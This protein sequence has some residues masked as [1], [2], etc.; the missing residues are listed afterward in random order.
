MKARSANDLSVS[1]ALNVVV[2]PRGLGGLDG[3]LWPERLRHPVSALVLKG[4]K[5]DWAGRPR[6]RLQPLEV[7]LPIGKSVLVERVLIEHSGE[8]LAALLLPDRGL[9]HRTRLERLS[10]TIGIDARHLLHTDEHRLALDEVSGP[11]V[12]PHELVAAH[13]CTSFWL[14][15]AKTRHH[16]IVRTKTIIAYIKSKVN[17]TQK[18][19]FLAEF[20]VSE[21]F[22]KFYF[23]QNRI[24][25]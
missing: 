25:N 17:S 24:V 22:Q 15:C 4:E 8:E 14:W 12:E 19:P 13:G 23:P 16:A 18:P 6:N 21:K 7:H 10:P 9:V 3:R 11:L 5:V 20:A 1:Y 2:V